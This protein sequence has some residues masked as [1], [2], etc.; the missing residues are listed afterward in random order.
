MNIDSKILNNVL[1][2]W[3]EQCIRKFTHLDHVEFIVG[4]QDWYDIPKLRNV[5]HHID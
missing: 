2:N 4:M 5:V 1:S 3:K